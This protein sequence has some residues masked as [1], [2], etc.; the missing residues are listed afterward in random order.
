VGDGGVDVLTRNLSVN[1]TA[2]L[3]GFVFRVKPAGMDRDVE[4]LPAAV[5][6]PHDKTGD[7]GGFSID[8][9][10]RRADGAGFSNIAEPYGHSLDG[11]GE[12]DNGGLPDGDGKF[13]GGV[14]G[15]LSIERCPGERHE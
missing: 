11:A 1:L 2:K 12:V 8:E 15:S 3:R 13:A 7:A 9:N 4:E 5:F 6:F 14:R 10:F